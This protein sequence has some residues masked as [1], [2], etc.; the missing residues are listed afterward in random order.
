MNDSLQLDDNKA[1]PCA[2]KLVFESEKD[3][4][5]ASLVAL[6]QHG[7]QLKVY[8]CKHCQLWHLASG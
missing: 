2:D 7:T 3:A 8:R 1:L 6:Y 4:R 5:V